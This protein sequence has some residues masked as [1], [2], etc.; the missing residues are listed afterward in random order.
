MLTY[1]VQPKGAVSPG[2][3]TCQGCMIDVIFRNALDVLG[4]DTVLVIPPGCAAQFSGCGPEASVTVPGIQGNLENSAALATGIANGFRHQGNEHTHVVV[5][6]GDGG[7]V[8]I[9]LQ[10]LSGAM[11]RNENILYICYDNE[12]YMNTGI[13]GSSSTPL[14]ASTTTTPAGKPVNSKDLIQIVMAHHVPYAATASVA[15]IPDLRR[16]VEKAR[17]IRGCRVLHIMSPCPTGWGYSPAK[18]VEVAREAINSG[19]WVLLEYENGKITLGKKPSDLG[20]ME[21]YFSLQKRFRNAGED[22]V[23]S[24]GE[25]IRERYAWLEKM[26]C[27]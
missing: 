18:T 8:D 24:A 26:S 21:K 19:A 12:A 3:N 9:G 6:A 17:D 4:D 23:R 2:M 10:S 14:A 7:T 16:K 27:L 5:I 1:K 25:H 11:E 22:A 20:N 13:Q 15:N